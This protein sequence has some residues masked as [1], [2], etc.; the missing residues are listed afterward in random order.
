MLFEQENS[1]LNETLDWVVKDPS[2]FITH[3]SLTSFAIGT[4]SKTS[5]SSRNSSS[6]WNYASESI[7]TWL[8][9]AL[10]V[11]IFKSYCDNCSNHWDILPMNNLHFW[12]SATKYSANEHS[13]FLGFCCEILCH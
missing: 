12:D 8:F 10:G 1:N 4:S 3:Y 11:P 5:S 6:P 9:T 2:N 13:V 7:I